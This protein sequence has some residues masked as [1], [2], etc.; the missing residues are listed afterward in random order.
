MIGIGIGLGSTP[1][2]GGGP[3]PPPEFPLSGAV[4]T[5]NGATLQLGS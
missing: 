4:L 2:G 3:P 5:L 1:P